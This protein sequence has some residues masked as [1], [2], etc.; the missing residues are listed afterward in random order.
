MVVSSGSGATFDFTPAE[1]GTY[2]VTFTVADDHGGNGSASTTL[3]VGVVEV[4]PDPC[5][6]GQTMLVSGGT[7]GDDRIVFKPSGAAG[8]ALVV[9]NGLTY[10]PFAPNGRLVAYGQGGGDDL[11]VNNLDN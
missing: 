9:V 7:G 10:G 3:S 4:Q 2:T 8:E 6:P 11:R 1:A 5:E